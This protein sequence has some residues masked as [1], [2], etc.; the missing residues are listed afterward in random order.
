[1]KRTVILSESQLNEIIKEVIKENNML[2]EGLLDK[3]IDPLR[4]TYHGFRGMVKGFGKDYFRYASEL[5]NIVRDLKKF[6]VPNEKIMI[7]LTNMYNEVQNLNM[8]PELKKNILDAIKGAITN[9]RMYTN[10]IDSLYNA[11]TK[12]LA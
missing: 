12:R 7:R 10:Y 4:N 8:R 1:M 2:N 5:K 3:V 9:F 6:D 11:V